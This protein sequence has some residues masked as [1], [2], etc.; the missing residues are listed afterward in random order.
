MARLV[1]LDPWS[2]YAIN[3]YKYVF[4]VSPPMSTTYRPIRSRVRERRHIIMPN[5]KN[6]TYLERKEKTYTIK[7]LGKDPKIPQKRDLR[8]SYTGISKFYLKILQKL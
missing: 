2:D 8:G 6:T 5:A 1:P 3:V 7:C 4:L